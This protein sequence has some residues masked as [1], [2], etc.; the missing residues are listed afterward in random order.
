[1]VHKMYKLL[2]ALIFFEIIQGRAQDIKFNG[3][4]SAEN[5]QIKNIVDPT[6]S[7]DAATKAYIDTLINNLQSQ[8]NDLKSTGSVP[9]NYVLLMKDDF[10]F[11]DSA[12]WSKGLTNDNDE[13]IRMLWNQN[14]GG[15][16]LLNDNYDG[17]LID[18]NVYV[19][20]GLLFLENKK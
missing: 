9:Y 10:D 5:N 19:N 12:N 13:T 16:H 3:T 15:E 20:N 11:F 17:Y 1:M 6:E 4:I 18:D 7:Q 8:L 2:F 14:T